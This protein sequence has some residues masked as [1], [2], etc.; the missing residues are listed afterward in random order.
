MCHVRVPEDVAEQIAMMSKM[1]KDIEDERVFETRANK[2][3]VL[4]R[5]LNDVYQEHA[6]SRR[7]I[8]HCGDIYVSLQQSAKDILAHANLLDQAV[9]NEI[10]AF[11]DMKK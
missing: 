9:A 11:L 7:S 5:F 4:F 1:M 6:L 10:V 8:L 3:G 2:I